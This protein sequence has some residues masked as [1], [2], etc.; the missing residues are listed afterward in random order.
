M[1]LKSPEKRQKFNRRKKGRNPL[2]A[3]AEKI[4]KKI[5]TESRSR[6]SHVSVADDKKNSHN[7]E[8]LL[9]LQKRS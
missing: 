1:R 9:S 3:T 5:A 7:S 2:K 4:S 6:Q 8:F